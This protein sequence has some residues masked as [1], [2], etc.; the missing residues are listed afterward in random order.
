MYVN[1]GGEDLTAAL[2]RQ[3]S[4]NV[5]VVGDGEYLSSYPYREAF[6]DS[7]NQAVS[8]DI[9][10]IGYVTRETDGWSMDARVD[11]YQGLKVVPIGNSAGEQVHI[12]HAP[13]FDL[14]GVDR[15]ISGTPLLWT[16]DSSAA[17]L[18]RVQPDFTSSGIIERFDVRPEVS[19]PLHF[20]GWSVLGSVASE[21]TVYSR[22]REAPYGASVAPVEL[23]QPLNR[24][25]VEIKAEVRPPVL[26]RTFAVPQFLQKYFGTEVR[27]TLEPAVT[28][29]DVKGVDNFLS[30]LRFDETDL[31]SD[32]NQLQY[33]LTQHLYFRPRPKKA[34]KLPANCPAATTEAKAT[35][36]AASTASGVGGT[37]DATTATEGN[38]AQ[39]EEAVPDVLTPGP[40][41]S[42]DANGIVTAASSV[43][44]TPLRTHARRAGRCT[45]P[46]APTQEAL[47]SWRL[48]QDYFFDPTF[49]NA[50]ILHRR[51]IFET[52]L[53]LSGIA[54]LTEPRNISPLVSRLR[55]RTS[56]HTDV[57]WDFDYDTG[58][59]RFTS[60][61]LYL[62]AH[63]GSVFG[64][65]SFARLN[66]P[67]RF[68]TELIDT[69]GNASLSTSPVS[70]FS[71]MRVLLGYGVPS[72]PGF[73]IATNVGLDLIGGDVQY[74]TIQGSYNWNCCG[75][76]VEY[77]KF[78]LGT[79]RD[80]NAYRFNFTLANIGSAG[81]IRRAERLF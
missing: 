30:V 23:T 58:A 41:D 16:L 22:S 4:P 51:N 76:A 26:E 31:V 32:T 53:S 13:S 34:P 81:N 37:A 18:K 5:R 39:A 12:L 38:L 35:G 56:G 46:A 8:S 40:A 1:Q 45:P 73:S 54:F 2:R 52:T 64:G 67:G 24:A 66:A 47:L 72:K 79:V 43:P 3:L 55:V 57:E 6:T 63:E 74:A 15:Q 60:S 20:D 33:G 29:E 11:R 17:G 71:Q 78:N 61:N 77:R 70:N 28:Y 49:G 25:D 68:A 50:V 27:H 9:T 65:F 21:E 69:A 48:T 36:S 7:F 14:F 10:S 42:T 44:E 19:L 62:D 80:E 59:K 75:L